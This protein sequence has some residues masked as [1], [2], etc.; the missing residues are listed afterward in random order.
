MKKQEATLPKETAVVTG[1]AAKAAPKP[2]RAGK[3]PP[4][5]KS[6]LPRKEK[7]ALARKTARAAL[8]AM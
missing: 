2:K 4:K 3:L 7:K 6:R 5:N 8:K 1:G